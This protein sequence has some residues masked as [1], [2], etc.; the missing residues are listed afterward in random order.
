MIP[1]SMLLRQQA[2]IIR[3]PGAYSDAGEWVPGAANETEM[4]CVTQPDTGQ[5][6]DLEQEGARTIGRRIFW[7]QDGTDVALPSATDGRATDQI[8][9]AG[10][11]FRVIDIQRFRGSHVRVLGAVVEGQ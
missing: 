3:T 2:T 5:E 6:R 7:F 9:Y 4:V 8:R 11:L 10:V 1:R